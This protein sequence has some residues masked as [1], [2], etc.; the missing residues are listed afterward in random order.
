MVNRVLNQAD[1][2]SSLLSR[3]PGN[4][5]AAIEWSELQRE[6]ALMR[7]R[8]KFCL[9]TGWLM[10]TSAA[11][12][13]AVVAW[14][15]SRSVRDIFVGEFGVEDASMY[16]IIYAPWMLIAIAIGLVLVGLVGFA[17]GGLPGIRST[18]SALDWSAASGAMARLLAVGTNY[19]ESFRA[20]A[21]SVPAGESRA[22]LMYAADRVEQGKS[23]TLSG[24]TNLDSP[25]VLALQGDR[26]VLELMLDAG[27]TAPQKQ[28][29]LATEHFLDMARRRL[30]LLTHSV[31]LVTTVLAGFLIWISI[32]ATLGWMWKMVGT[33]IRGFSY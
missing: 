11:V 30:M 23:P 19:P 22:W 21:Q 20:A 5:A 24:G 13:S 4:E 16:V 3:T 10:L 26:A 31:P 8:A 32:S 7:R 28:W 6:I 18:F 27:E 29:Q 2:V 1:A 25:S 17:S 15:M 14:M 33:M 12:V 9:L